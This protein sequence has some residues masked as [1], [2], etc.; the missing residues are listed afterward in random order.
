MHICVDFDGTICDNTRIKPGFRMGEP[1]AGAKE[2]LQYFESQNWEIIVFT[3]RDR[4]SPVMD[5]LDHFEIPYSRVTNIK[6]PEAD[7]FIDDRA[8]HFESW[9]QII[10]S[11]T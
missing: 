3:A 8:V 5:W 1:M 11:L 2:A 10:D 9:A 4:F 6:P 7:L